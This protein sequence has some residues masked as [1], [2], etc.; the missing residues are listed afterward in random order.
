[1]GKN[2]INKREKTRNKPPRRRHPQNAIK[3]SVPGKKT[4][5]TL[6]PFFIP[7]F[8]CIILATETAEEQRRI[9]VRIEEEGRE[10]GGEGEDGRDVA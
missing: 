5:P 7:C 9:R 6:S 1:M 4:R 2:F 3:T 10:V 8:L